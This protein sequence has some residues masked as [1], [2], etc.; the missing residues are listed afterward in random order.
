VDDS[1]ALLSGS[2]V[3]SEAMLKRKDKTETK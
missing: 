2:E 3:F 1:G